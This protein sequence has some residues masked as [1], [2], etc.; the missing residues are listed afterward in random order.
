MSDSPK[1][2]A[3][4]LPPLRVASAVDGFNV[5]AG[6]QPWRTPAGNALT[7]PTREL[8]E[9]IVAEIETARD[10]MK[11]GKLPIEALGLTRLAATAI[12]RIAPIPSAMARALLEFAE[13]DLVC[14][15]SEVESELRAR[16]DAAWQPLLTWLGE[17]FNAHLT[18]VE[19]VMPAP[20]PSLALVAL[21]AT[22]EKYDAFILSGLGLAVQS[23]GSLVIGLALA[24]GR[25]DA[26][27][28]SG[29]ADL[30]EAYQKEKWGEDEEAIVK[31][32]LRVTDMA[33]ASSFLTLLKKMD[34]GN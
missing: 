15:R 18:V 4:P 28:A 11:G 29:L 20:Q 31:R 22:L 9:A 23:A 2:A 1:P 6:E 25:I 13:T 26:A 17:R 3:K 16:Q 30:D 24:H 8:A 32:S 21:S 10:S 27:E 12:D 14:Y 7:V 19:G 34:N 5:M 33:L